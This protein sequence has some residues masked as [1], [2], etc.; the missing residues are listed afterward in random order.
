M[1]VSDERAG[2]WLAGLVVVPDR[3]SHGQDAL[4]DPD[5]D[6]FEGAAS[7]RAFAAHCDAA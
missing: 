2:D 4:R 1:V 3:G 6:A 5:G 7:P